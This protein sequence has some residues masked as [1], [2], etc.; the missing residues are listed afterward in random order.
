MEIRVLEYFLAVAR[1]QTISAAAE[2]LHLT[3]PTLSRQ[4]HDLEEQLGKQLFHRGSHRITLT[5][6]GMLLRQRAEQIVELVRKTENEITHNS[7]TISGDIFIGS[8][9]TDAVRLVASVAAD[10]QKDFDDIHIHIYSGDGEDIIDRIDR[11][12][13]DFG[14]IFEPYDIS[15]YENISIPLSDTW[16]VL[17]RRD[18]PMA[19]KNTITCED[20]WD[21][22][23]ILSRQQVNLSR[24]QTKK[25]ALLKWLGKDIS[26]L[27]IAA[28]YNLVYNGSLMAG[29]GVGY[30]ITLDKLINVSG[31]SN[32]CFIPLYPAVDAK[33]NL[34]WSKYRIMTRAADEF[35]SRFK[36]KAENIGD[37]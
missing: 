32:L 23:L 16:G 6:E 22:P 28:T 11:G 25:S 24:I 26:R 37:F 34:V 12:L 5:D 20:L 19:D 21:K 8:G 33:M 17:M 27:N 3:Q 4:L 18:D 36:I 14:I 7:D 9:E 30:V 2:S 15:K 10:M 35:L 29:E 13:I 1:E 31:N